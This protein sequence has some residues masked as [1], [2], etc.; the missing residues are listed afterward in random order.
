[1]QRGGLPEGGSQVKR[2]SMNQSDHISSDDAGPSRI[3]PL[4]VLL[5]LA[6][7]AVAGWFGWHQL[8][9]DAAR[10]DL[11]GPIS[12]RSLNGTWAWSGLEN[13]KNYYR[14]LSFAGQ[15]I[16]AR[17]DGV[18]TIDITGA[19]VEKLDIQ[20]APTVA[21]TYQLNGNDYESH[22]RFESINEIVLVDDI[23]NGQPNPSINKARGK[24]LV[25]CPQLDPM[26]DISF[27]SEAE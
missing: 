6:L 8:Q 10:P 11:T 2:D 25:R 21:V 22:Y 23:M 12:A 27:A 20:I 14:T 18:G 24:K 15:R 4:L 3:K 16:Y 13:C 17:E 1:M 5:A 9:K 7:L 26:P 19:K